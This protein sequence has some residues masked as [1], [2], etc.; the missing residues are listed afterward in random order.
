[1]HLLYVTGSKYVAAAVAFGLALFSHIL[2]HVVI[3]LQSALYEL[4][5]PRRVLHVD[6][7]GNMYL[8]LVCV[9]SVCVTHSACYS[10]S[11][12]HILRMSGQEE[13]FFFKLLLVEPS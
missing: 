2:N 7:A 5:N 8:H 4:E 12:G 3:R 1:M 6:S 9:W 13:K 11:S 10:L